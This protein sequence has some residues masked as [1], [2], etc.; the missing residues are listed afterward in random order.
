MSSTLYSFIRKHLAYII[1]IFFERGVSYL[2]LPLYTHVL[3][4]HEYGIYALL[5]TFISIAVF[6]YSL[7]LENSLLTYGAGMKD[8][9][10]L[11][12]TIFWGMMVL[13]TGFSL[14]IF[15]F[16][17]QLSSV[18]LGHEK[19]IK[20]VR[21]CGG[22]LLTET[23]IRFSLY[24]ILGEQK[25]KIY[26][27]ILSS[28][29]VLTVVFNVYFLLILKMRL[30][31]LFLSYLV[32]TIIV[33]SA[34]IVRFSRMLRPF[35]DRSLFYR[36]FYFG[37]PVMLTSLL[38]TG[39]N[40]FDRFLLNF[41][42]DASVVGI[43]S[44]AYKIGFV[45][46]VIVIAFSMGA[47]PMTSSLLK[48]D[49]RNADI[50]PD[51][52]KWLFSVML[53]VLVFLVLF[54]GDIVRLTFFG[55]TLINESYLGAV[56]LI[57]IILLG[58]L[59]YGFYITFSLGIYFKEK[60]KILAGTAAFGFCVNLVFNLILI[61]KYD[62]LGASLATVIAFFSMA[63]VLYRYSGSIFPVT[64]AWKKIGIS[65]LTGTL[66]AGFSMCVIQENTLLKIVLYLVFQISIW[67]IMR[68]R[69]TSPT[70]I[71]AT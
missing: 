65:F 49:A 5:L 46:N 11:Y 60:T 61:P 62:A 63:L 13:G 12:S 64:Y 32:T 53:S 45:M 71:S 69:H 48:D 16:A 39:L 22:I 42:H 50:L 54:A 18:Y 56:P 58:Y 55:Y 9:T 33:A 2:L 8:R 4:P 47:I 1:G 27:I 52:L 3:L 17:G 34:C 10:I 38:I 19:Y 28:K 41:Y 15:L 36:V 51:L 30:E 44:V 20:L 70:R 37:F 67:R 7:G 57:P 29:A 68:S 24:G 25:P 35:F 23:A 66:I 14:L 6:I 40:F 31:G 26:L 59:F 21:L 43:Y